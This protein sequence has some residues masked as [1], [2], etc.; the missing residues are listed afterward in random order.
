M[1][2]P[3]AD[4]TFDIV[5]CQL[6]LQFFTDR[7]EALREMARVLVPGGRVA[8]MVWRAMQYTPGFSAFA[9]ALERHVS[10][11]AAAIMRAP[12]TLG[13][14]EELRTLLV[15][16][17]FH[18]VEIRPVT[19]TVRFPSPTHL[20]QS[21]VAGSPLASHV[22]N[23]TEAARLALIQEVDGALRSYMSE[24][25]LTFPIEAHL[26]SAKK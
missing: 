16:A 4:A 1:A 20:V 3:L 23:A 25:G 7:P 6:G 9:T 18:D 24:S 11:E 15:A 26:A 19:G 13:E 12:F 21:Y 8:L 10:A 14:A 5:Y 22:A 17:G 2:L